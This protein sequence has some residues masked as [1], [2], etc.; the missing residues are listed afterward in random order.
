LWR[1]WTGAK[2][3][4]VDP[5]APLA[6]LLVMMGRGQTRAPAECADLLVDVLARA[7][8]AV[9]GAG[10]S[11][12]VFLAHLA[13][14]LRDRD[15][16][17]S[18][19]SGL[20]VEDLT[21]ACACVHGDGVAIAELERR[22]VSQIP[23]FLA[24]LRQS[25]RFTA[26]VAQLVREK[27]LVGR[28]GAPGKLAEYR[29]TGPLG[30]WLRVVAVRIAQDLLRAPRRPGETSTSAP[31]QPADDPDPEVTYL[32]R[33]CAAQLDQAF[34]ETLAALEP[35]ERAMLSLTFLDGLSS[36]A[37]GKMYGIDGSTVR[38]RLQALREKI[39][40]RTRELLAATLGADEREIDSLI[41]FVKSRVDLDLSAVLRSSRSA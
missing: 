8:R 24:S 6:Q 15:D 20:H 41:D 12:D 9:G 32:K 36:G 26:E 22:H 31:P 33:R 29:G 17:A 23:L 38:R 28:D 35:E 16:L 3:G 37:I 5:R 21:L 30:G 10:L 39:L 2:I 1:R 13:S 11:D 18:A 14:A 27:L 25:D 34:R 40:D 7:R 4:A 19:L